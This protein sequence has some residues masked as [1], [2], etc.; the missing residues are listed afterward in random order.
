MTAARTRPGPVARSRAKRR[1]AEGPVARK[2]RAECVERDGH[3]IFAPFGDC[4]DWSEWMHLGEKRRSKTRG[5]RPEQRHTIEG[6][7]MGC[8]KHHRKYD[9]G[10]IELALGEKGANGVMRAVYQG[11]VYMLIPLIRRIEHVG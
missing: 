1:R 6:S 7:A 11:K 4:S 2:V 5:M 10:E 9:H 8:S 3:C